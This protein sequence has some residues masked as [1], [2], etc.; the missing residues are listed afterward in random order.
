MLKKLR[1]RFVCVILAI[2]TVMLCL[3]FGLL[4]HS[5]AQNLEEESLSMMRT[6]AANPFQ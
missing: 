4:Y 6:V 2:V 3:I 5:T 1:I